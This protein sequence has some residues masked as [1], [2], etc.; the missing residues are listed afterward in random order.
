MNHPAILSSRACRVA[1][2]AGFVGL[3]SCGSS[4]PAATPSAG[5][6]GSGGSATMMGTAGTSSTGGAI[7][8]GAGGDAG[9]V[10]AADAAAPNSDDGG[11]TVVTGDG[12]LPPDF[13]KGESNS[14]PGGP[15]KTYTAA[16]LFKKCA[17]LDG[18]PDD[19][20]DQHDNVTMYD[21]Y[22]LMPWAPETGGGGVNFFD[23]SDPCAPKQVGYG[24]SAEMRESHTTA[25]SNRAGG[26]WLALDMMRTTTVKASVGASSGT[27]CAWIAG[28]T[29]S[30]SDRA[31]VPG[32]MSKAIG[33]G[34]V[35]FTGVFPTAI[36]SRARELPTRRTRAH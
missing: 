7:D 6:G 13:G 33:S 2:L 35:A 17:A 25:I 8:P 32:G 30:T 31:V 15:S 18:G 11:A 26:K 22:L 5:S 1:L 4:E 24:Y 12:G 29:V 14:G 19:V 28:K 21:G 9:G 23:I 20:K 10:G 27:C 16:Q 34:N 36:A 3:A